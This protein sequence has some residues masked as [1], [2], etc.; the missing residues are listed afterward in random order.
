MPVADLH[1]HFPMHLVPDLQGA[2]AYELLAT[3][4]GR[5]RLRDRLRARVVGAL[6]R[7]MNYRSLSS[8]PRVTLDGLRDGDV[9]VALSVLYS[10]FAEMDLGEPYG[11]RPLPAYL[12]D[13]HAQIDLVE[14]ALA[15]HEA[16]IRVARGPADVDAALADGRTALVHCVEG[17]FH[18]GATPQEV[19]AGVG[20]L[21]ARGV[22]YITL[23]HLFWR[24]VATNAP[25]LPFLPDAL[26]RRVFPQPPVGLTDLGRAAITAMVREGV[27]VDLAH[28]STRAVADALALL[29]E[30]D[31]GRGVAVVSSHAGYRFG[32]QEYQVDEPTLRRI[33]ERDG[34]V[35]L[36]FAEHQILDGLGRRRTTTFEQSV[37]ALCRH[38][39]R[40]AEVTGSHR[41]VA[42]G[43]D[44]DGFIKP[45]LAGLQSAADLA[46]LRAPLVA[47]YGAGDADAILAGNVVRV[48]RAT[49][50]GA[51]PA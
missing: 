5:R 2:T 42:L 21:A 44:L 37:D 14:R 48:L 33:G 17:G 39:D 7:V 13:V 34:V 23:A 49:W 19:D 11:A 47:R 3:P 28:M 1:I 45:T 9:G 8:G 51:P 20:A 30:L 35:G 31:P 22:A 15:G 36:I 26:Y 4:R 27:I 25:A 18:L 29:D 16:Q 12:A 38:I 40:I 24:S 6:G 32:G 50:R 10:P 46:R 43:S 41:H